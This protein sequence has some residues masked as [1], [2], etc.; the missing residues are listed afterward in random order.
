MAY[1]ALKAIYECDLAYNYE[2]PAVTGSVYQTT[3]GYPPEALSTYVGPRWIELDYE[4]I[5]FRSAAVEYMRPAPASWF[6]AVNYTE[7]QMSQ[8]ISKDAYSFPQD[9]PFV[10]WSVGGPKLKM[11]QAL[12]SIDPAWNVCTVEWLGMVDPP[13]AL[14]KVTAFAA[15]TSDSSPSS[16][17][18]PPSPGSGIASSLLLPSSTLPP[19]ARTTKLS[20]SLP[21]PDPAQGPDPFSA[22]TASQKS[23]DPEHLAT[24]DTVHS[25][26]PK[27]DPKSPSSPKGSISSQEKTSR[28]SADIG[29]QLVGIRTDDPVD[30]VLSMPFLAP[31][32]QPSADSESLHGGLGVASNL[33]N[34]M[35]LTTNDGSQ[36]TETKHAGMVDPVLATASTTAFSIPFLVSGS[37]LSQNSYIGAKSSASRLL[38]DDP[39]V[40]QESPSTRHGRA[41]S[42]GVVYNEKGGIGSSTI[43]QQSENSNAPVVSSDGSN[44]IPSAE[45]ALLT[46][47]QTPTPKQTPTPRSSSLSS[48]T[49]SADYTTIF[50]I[51]SPLPSASDP[52]STSAGILPFAHSTLTADTASNFLISSK[53]HSPGKTIT[54][55]GTST[56]YAPETTA[57][58][59]SGLGGLIMSGFGP[60]PPEMTDTGRSAS[61]G[62]HTVHAGGVFIGKAE[63]CAGKGLGKVGWVIVGLGVMAVF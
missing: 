45:S 37:K 42:K 58:P 2:F 38:T 22:A 55:D 26:D 6:Q 61:S 57:A 9:S 10:M 52:P 56:S 48:N 13:R 12:K 7:L 62:N 28:F 15:P 51:P 17:A 53:T 23:T 5:D 4:G 44:R 1:T 49:L 8:S 34:T 54:V 60:G 27:S 35:G 33:E 32:F 16:T 63:R 20:P 14:T 59:V 29:N 3:I 40:P 50:S 24:G 30:P 25:E 39:H 19:L 21:P 18:D 11:P 47:N 31:P 43:I 41:S 36:A 46:T